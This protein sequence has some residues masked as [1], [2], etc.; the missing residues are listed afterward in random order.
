MQNLLLP[1]T[2]TETIDN[3][4]Q[5]IHNR[6]PLYDKDSNKFYIKYDDK[7][8]LIRARVDNDNII[9]NDN[10]E[11]T[12]A[13]NIHCTSAT[14]K[15][16][17]SG[18][19]YKANILFAETTDDR[20]IIL[21]S[22]INDNNGAISGNLYISG[23]TASGGYH[24]TVTS[25]GTRYLE[26]A[27]SNGAI[28]Y[29]RVTYNNEDYIGIRCIPNTKI[30]FS[31]YDLRNEDILP[32][33]YTEY[34]DKSHSKVIEIV[35]ESNNKTENKEIENPA[36]ANW[37]FTVPVAGLDEENKTTPLT[38]YDLT[39]GLYINSEYD[40]SIYFY[41]D[42]RT[43]GDKGYIT[44]GGMGKALKLVLTKD[45]CVLK[46][47]FSSNVNGADAR[48]LVIR[49]ADEILETAYSDT[50]DV[51]STLK[52]SKLD[53]GTYY[54]GTTNSRIRIYK[55]T[56]IPPQ[57]NVKVEGHS[58]INYD[59]DFRQKPADWVDGVSTDFKN[60]LQMV[61]T[62]GSTYKIYGNTTSYN[63]TGYF[64]NNSSNVYVFYIDVP[65]DNA[66]F[67]IKFTT[68]RRGANRYASISDNNGNTIVDSWTGQYPNNLTTLTCKVN[69]GRYYIWQNAP[70]QIYRINLYIPYTEQIEEEISYADK[71][72]ESLELLE[73]TG[74]TGDPHHMKVLDIALSLQ[75]L[76]D[77]ADKLRDS[78]R[79]IHLDLTE[80]FVKDDA[81]EW[82][83]IFNKCLSLSYLGMPQGVTKIGPDTFVG[84][85]F[86]EKIK[87]CE[88]ITEFEAGSNAYV[89]SG[90]RARTFVLPYKCAK[91]G[92]NTFANS[93][94]RHIIVPPNSANTF[95]SMLTYG[96][97]FNTLDYV[98]I[99][100]TQEEFNKENYSLTWEHNNYMGDNKDTRISDHITIYDDLDKL[101]S[102][103]NYGDDY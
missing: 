12:L 97:F 48:S 71:I 58:E 56:L 103:L 44:L 73:D 95:K 70:L 49:N 52:T 16:D 7:L 14:V 94:A 1:V 30:Y 40:N 67:T 5:D 93:G 89:F 11:L 33:N 54:I 24:F 55:I 9:F 21:I 2:A 26:G 46:V 83:G 78:D 79:K 102:E 51:I 100:M 31:G 92:W 60:G 28:T 29:V 86:L 75:D 99:Y 80:C 42:A 82:N 34:D 17:D 19:V 88:S 96:S 64:I 39:D 62:E 8:N 65:Y 72:K 47:L 45:N 59:W 43:N 69:K 63:D 4:K 50:K 15:P 85:I 13:D 81:K 27:T 68:G 23:D 57:V 22:K 18:I 74:E 41:P 101:L 36:T 98:K 91:I 3:A 38:E 37:D 25:A 84:C 10:D 77:I 32:P 90:N 76:K 6:S 53:K 61:R 66:T 35:D 20:T 87:F